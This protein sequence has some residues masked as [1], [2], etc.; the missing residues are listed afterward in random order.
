MSLAPK[1][2]EIRHVADY[3]NLDCICVTESWLQSHISDDVIALNGF[4]IARMDRSH[5]V[6]RVVC[7][8]IS[9]NISFTVLKD[10]QDLFFEVLWIKLQPPRLPRGYTCIVL[11]TV[12]HPPSA[13][14]SA[15]LDYLG[16]SLSSIESK[17]SNCRFLIVGDLN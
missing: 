10:L 16:Q 7:C 17:F 13:D 9:V 1:I 8:Y 11:G 2:D 5:T 14:D 3:A 6:H 15:I 12:Y 4:N